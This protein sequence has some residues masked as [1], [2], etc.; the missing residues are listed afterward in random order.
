MGT[1]W[2]RKDNKWRDDEAEGKRKKWG[3][4]VDRCCAQ[5][6]SEACNAGGPF[7]IESCQRRPRRILDDRSCHS[8]L[9]F[10]YILQQGRWC[11]TPHCTTVL[12]A[13]TNKCNKEATNGHS[14]HVV[15]ESK[16]SAQVNIASNLS[17][18]TI[19]VVVPAEIGGQSNNKVGMIEHTR[20]IRIRKA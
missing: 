15:A 18:Q 1:V 9:D 16:S 17:A 19:D 20:Y 5:G 13:W 10:L 11:T 3:K 12:Q 14:M 6:T 2:Q 8:K 7:P 4:R